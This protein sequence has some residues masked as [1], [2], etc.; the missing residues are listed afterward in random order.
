MLH[1]HL[2]AP[3]MAAVFSVS[4]LFL[5][6]IARPA[7]ANYQLYVPTLA[8]SV[9]QMSF[10]PST[11][12]DH[13]MVAYE[14]NNGQWDKVFYKYSY[15]ITGC[16]GSTCSSNN[17]INSNMAGANIDTN[18]Y[19]LSNN[20]INNTN[21][22]IGTISG[23]FLNNKGSRGGAIFNTE[24][25]NGI[26]KIG[27]MEGDFVNNHA[28]VYGGAIANI[29][30]SGQ[31][32]SQAI[33][34]DIK[35]NFIGNRAEG[36]GGA[37]YNDANSPSKTAQIGN[38]NGDFIA[39]SSGD[40]GGAIFNNGIIGNITGNFISN[41]GY[42][43][44]AILHTYKMGDIAADF[45]ANSAESD[46]GALYFSNHASIGQI[47]GDFVGNT[48]ARN[49]GAIFNS[50]TEELNITGNFINNEAKFGGAMVNISDPDG[51]FSSKT[52]LVNTSFI[53]NTATKAGGAIY[54]EGVMDITA[55]NGSSVF[56]GNT[57]NGVSN[58][59][60]ISNDT[61]N[62]KISSVNMNA[63][64][65]GRIVISDDVNGDEAYKLYLS[66][67]TSSGIDF[68]ANI[69]NGD[70]IIGADNTTRSVTDSPNVG[71]DN[72]ANISNRNNSL[73]LNNGTLTFDNFEL[74]RHHFRDLK[75]TGGE[76]N[77]NNVNA[78]LANTTMGRFHADNYTGGDATVKVHN[79][80]VVSDG[81]TY[82]AIDFADTS[83]S[84][85]VENNVS[86]AIGPV[87]EYSVAYLPNTG[88]Y[89]FT[90]AGVNNEVK[91]PSYAAVA[92]VSIL[93][94]EIYSRILSN[95]DSY[96]DN[97]PVKEGIKP[98][99]KV[100]GSDD[101]T[102]LKNVP[103]GDSKFYGAIFGL[104]SSPSD[105]LF[106][107]KAVYNGYLAYARGEHKYA[108]ERVDQESGYI[109]A[110]ALFYKGN[111]FAG[112]TIN[113][114]IVRNQSKESG[115]KNKFTS[116]L[117]GVA[118][119][120]GYNYNFGDNYTFQPNLYASYTYINSNDYK[121]KR[122]AT[123]K[124]ND[125]SNIELAP[126][127]KLAKKFEEGLS[128]YA[129]GRYVFVFNEHQDAKANDVRLPDI[130]LKNYAEFGI[131]IEKDWIEKDLN[132]F[133]EVS[134][135]EGGREGWNSLAGAKWLF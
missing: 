48:A 28:D 119:K 93:S 128:L 24:D 118:L 30:I 82:T 81:G 106:G 14:N 37:I 2:E 97:K 69:N 54:H 58:S 7:S 75:L 112:S 57:A 25:N 5:T 49:G 11:E 116:Y 31:P 117:G 104:E 85:Q 55:D 89:T 44:G 121:T 96:L 33:I 133:L 62:N 52:S 6:A 99:A 39:N 76:I 27:N 123:V 79:V 110:S 77:I 67:D 131:G 43:G 95:A 29:T 42:D 68:H 16:S 13:N 103:G 23:D 94:D 124:F 26:A 84:N 78:D 100:F 88:Q 72:I 127:V 101:N 35:G 36:L 61:D 113:A 9:Y 12:S 83:F 66:T 120:T 1:K 40:W 20:A 60:Y 86:S 32:T 105:S 108:S 46:G 114:A 87:H 111:F 122:G 130:E 129:K 92:A 21:R 132:L 80:N 56:S 41:N 91:L 71:F 15:Q 98:F 19:G 10:T 22:N 125:I 107:G 115:E 47:S 50:G 38:I 70:I 45:I 135:R 65:N 134:R 53:N 73:I 126:G 64:N 63:V 109:G 102:D 3:H 59:L 74:T 34:G 90:R 8:D 18:F 4:A 51:Y 17:R